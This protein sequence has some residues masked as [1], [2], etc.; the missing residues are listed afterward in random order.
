MKKIMRT[1]LTKQLSMLQAAPRGGWIKLIRE[2]L[3]MSTRQLAKRLHV[4]QSRVSQIEKN[5]ASQALSLKALNEVAE[6]LN[7]KLCYTLVPKKDLEFLM[8]D[9]AKKKAQTYLK[10]VGHSMVLESQGISLESQKL[11]LEETVENI[12]KKPHLLWNEDED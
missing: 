3:C 5:E 4:S 7:C 6:A 8:Q 1:Q 9:Q 10:T 11:I 12:L 2:A